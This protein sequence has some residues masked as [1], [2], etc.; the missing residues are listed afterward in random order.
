[1]NQGDSSP[2]PAYDEQAFDQKISSALQVSLST[3]QP[4]QRNEERW[5]EWD[6]RVFDA[7]A[8]ALS[9][10]GS[11]GPSGSSQAGS[12]ARS[13]PPEKLDD[14]QSPGLPIIEPL[15]IHKKAWSPAVQSKPRPSWFSESEG[16]ARSSAS[17]SST[18]QHDIPPE[19]E[20]DHSIP[21]PPFTAIAPSLD[22]QPVI[23][24]AY[25]PSGELTPPSPLHSPI[26]RSLE[27]P[28]SSHDHVS[29]SR[30]PSRMLPDQSQLYAEQSRPHPPI[31]RSLPAPPHPHNVAQQ[32]ST[33]FSSK[34]MQ[35]SSI[36]RM[37][38]NPSVAYSQGGGISELPLARYPTQ[39]FDPN[40]FY[41]YG[42]FLVIVHPLTVFVVRLYLPIYRREG[43]LPN[44][45]IRELRSLS[46][47]M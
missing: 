47:Y 25:H 3:P 20:E 6:D 35:S 12:S 11:H 8:Q 36:P 16:D 34:P 1:M 19:D 10:W 28:A 18:L 30:P 26:R 46:F 29:P 27:F 42:S 43:R 38:F 17:T 32:P 5:E 21:P 15:R 23:V 31:R 13:H 4:P 7:A 41:K 44:N 2:P 40:G 14:A 33:T 22:G 39:Q 45:H 24:M 37:N 9:S